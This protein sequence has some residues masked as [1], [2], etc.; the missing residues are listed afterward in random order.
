[1][2]GQVCAV[3]VKHFCEGAIL[4]LQMVGYLCYA[5]EVGGGL[6]T[7]RI[8]H[9]STSPRVGEDKWQINFSLGTSVHRIPKISDVYFW[10][11]EVHMHM[12]NP[13]NLFAKSLWK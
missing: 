1:M 2:L 7:Q 13:D 10:P 9:T 4:P 11:A 6:S 5:R 8:L 3:C 12:Y